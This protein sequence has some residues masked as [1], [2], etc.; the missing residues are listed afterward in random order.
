MIEWMMGSFTFF[1]GAAHVFVRE[2]FFRDFIDQNDFSGY[3]LGF[4]YMVMK[5]DF[6]EREFCE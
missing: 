5:I 2:L 1:M 6:N 4:I 3:L